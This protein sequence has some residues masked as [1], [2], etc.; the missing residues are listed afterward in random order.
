MWSRECRK[1]VGFIS[2]NIKGMRSHNLADILDRK[3]EI[4]IRNGYRCVMPF[5][6]LVF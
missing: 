3:F 4:A 5:N 6:M 2:F 1:E